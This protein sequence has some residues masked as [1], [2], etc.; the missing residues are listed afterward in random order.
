MCTP[1]EVV[2][3]I[4]LLG[5]IRCATG[6]MLPL[7]QTVARKTEREHTKQALI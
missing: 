3:A 5:H 2:W 1:A 7:V 4:Q 6:R